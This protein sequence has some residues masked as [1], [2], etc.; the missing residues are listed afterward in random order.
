[1]RTGG[2]DLGRIRIGDQALG[3]R[4]EVVVHA[5]E[6]ADLDRIGHLVLA[7]DV[8]LVGGQCHELAEAALRRQNVGQHA[9]F[10]FG[11][12]GGVAIERTLPVPPRLR[13][14]RRAAAW[15][16]LA[17]SYIGRDAQFL[18]GIEAIEALLAG[19]R[20]SSPC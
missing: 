17:R 1:M 2:K 3:Q 9:G 20:R 6:A 13:R 10:E 7:D 8:V 15:F 18:V 12:V 16:G 19:Q 11:A 4:F 14:T 5:R